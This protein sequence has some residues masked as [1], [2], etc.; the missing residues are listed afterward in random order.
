MTALEE[1]YVVQRVRVA[2]ESD[3][4]REFKSQQRFEWQ[5]FFITL[6]ACA[7]TNYLAGR[8]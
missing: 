8:G 3:A 2:T 4:N 7:I 6:I 1:R 5:W